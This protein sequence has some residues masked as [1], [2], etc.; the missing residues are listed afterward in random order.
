M[1]V[2]SN[3]RREAFCQNLVRGMPKGE[4]HVKAGYKP[5]GSNATLLSQEPEIMARCQELAEE[6]KAWLIAVRAEEERNF[7]E[8]VNDGE[9]AI[10]SLKWLVLQARENMALAREGIR[11]GDANDALKFIAQLCGYL[12]T[13]PGKKPGSG[14]RSYPIKTDAL[15]HDGAFSNVSKKGPLIDQFLDRFDDEDRDSGPDGEASSTGNVEASE[16]D[17]EHADE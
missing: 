9:R 7:Q 5:N 14:G 4:A 1:P 15:P 3:P 12:D 11:V 6:R 17:A 2:L 16:D 8:Q 13:M 10:V